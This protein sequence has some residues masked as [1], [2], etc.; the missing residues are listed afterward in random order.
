MIYLLKLEDKEADREER[1]KE[2]RPRCRAARRSGGLAKAQR[3][4]SQSASTAIRHDILL[5]PTVRSRK[6]IGTSTHGTRLHRPVCQLDLERVALGAHGFEVDR[7][8]HGATEALETTREVLDTSP[9]TT[10]RR[11]S[12]RS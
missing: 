8:E 12:R 6:T 3:R 7:F 10:A 4:T 9:S 1:E 11:S 2:S 5:S